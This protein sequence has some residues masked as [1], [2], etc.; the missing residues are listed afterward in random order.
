MKFIND[1]FLLQTKSAS[2]LYHEYAENQP[3]I[4]YHCHLNPEEIRSD[5]SWENLTQVWLYGDHYKWRAMR[6]NGVSEDYCTGDKTD[7]EKFHKFA[8]TMPY[9]LR[10]PLYHWC[11][12]ELARYFD[13][14]DLLLSGDTAEKIWKK[15]EDILKGGLSAR[16]LMTNSNVTV[17]CT[18]D[19]PLDSLEHHKALAMDESFSVKVLPTWRPDKALAIDKD[20]WNKYI[21]DLAVAA[22]KNI[23]TYTELVEALRIRHS[24]F[25]DNG[26]RLSD[27]GLDTVYASDFSEA[28]IDSIF[29]RARSGG[30][31][32][33]VEADKYRSAL[34][35]DFGRMDAEKGWTKQ[36]HIGALRNN[37]TRLFS[38]LG[39]D[40]GFDSID[41]QTY[42]R[43][44][45][46]YLNK[47]DMENSLPKTILYNL[48]P[49]DNEVIGTM[50]GNF[51]DGSVAGKLQ[52]GSGWWFLD[53]KDGMTRQ[54]EALSQLGALSRFVGMLTDSRSFL[55]YTRHEYFRR[56]LCNILGA[57][58]ENGLIPDDFNLVGNMVSDISFRNADRYFGF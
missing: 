40:T 38:K 52:M 21:N 41:D 17:V 58:M 45:S 32:S 19:D 10:N 14:D 53:Q 46:S 25:H 7:R 26:C 1:D 29:S 22:D 28:E 3:I 30:V 13:I 15:T 27:H 51:Q 20:F 5:I 50:L 9:L 47:L 16:K 37:N 2:R 55:S 18:T 8:E 11:H 34:M 35:L 23:S 33:T 36:L 39:P 6:T 48:N 42:A 57:D 43:P 24:F 44:L 56:I 49:R 31:V 4:D 54:I 12:L